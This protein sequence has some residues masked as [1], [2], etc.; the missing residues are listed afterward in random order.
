MTQIIIAFPLALLFVTLS[1]QWSIGGLTTGYIIGLG[2]VSLTGV[3][4]MRVNILR[5]P[6]QIFWAVIYIARLFIDI[7]LSSIDVT[8]RVL[9]PNLPI[10]PDEIAV[11]V[12]DKQHRL[13]VSALSAHAITVTPGELVVDF[14]TRADEVVMIVHT[15]DINSSS[16]KINHEQL[17]RLRLIHR[18]LGGQTQ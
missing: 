13:L 6:M 5:L 16:S 3:G 10:N 8:W 4:T 2:V 12:Q 14:E 9:H 11:A 7:V 17:S 15:L 18:I 1:D